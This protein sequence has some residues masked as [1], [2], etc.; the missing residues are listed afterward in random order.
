VKCIDRLIVGELIG[1]WFFG[2]AIFTVLIAAGQFLFQITQYLASGVDI[3][4]TMQLLSYLMPGVIVK[5]FSMSMLLS[6]LLAFGRL[7]GD[8]EIVAMRAGGISLWRIMAPVAVFGALASVLAFAFG[9]YVV[10][11]ATLKALKIQLDLEAESKNRREQVTSRAIYK[12]GVLQ[13]L[14]I[15]RDFDIANQVLRGVTIVTYNAAGEEEL[16]VSSPRMTFENRTEWEMPEGGRMRVLESG[17]LID[18][19]GP[20][21]PTEVSNPDV[22]PDDLIAQALR[23]LDALSMRQMKTQIEREKS[24]PGYSKKQVANLEFGYWNKVALPLAALVFGLVGAPLGIRSHRAGTATGFALSVVII[25]GYMMLANAM[26]IMAQ[27]GRVPAYVAS[28]SP[29]VIGLVVGIVLI[30]RRNR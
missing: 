15:A 19:K 5:T 4:L 7:S 3:W 11:G 22:T 28:F 20:A 10:P 25:F 12:D 27:G 13:M 8:S 29:I 1:P 14:L 26:S 18:F 23:Q 24:R 6:T 17:V 2:V 9:E 21:L 16:I 30:H